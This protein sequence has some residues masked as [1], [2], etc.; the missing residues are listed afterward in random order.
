MG[1][2]LSPK[3][4]RPSLLDITITYQ[5]STNGPTLFQ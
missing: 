4:Q 1:L 3:L 2:G 5:Q